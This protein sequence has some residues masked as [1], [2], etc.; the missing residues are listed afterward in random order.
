MLSIP[1]FQ[2]VPGPLDTEGTRI[3]NEML[4]DS[5]A[6]MPG[7]ISSVW[8][9]I[10]EHGPAGVLVSL[11]ITAIPQPIQV[12]LTARAGTAYAWQEMQ[13]AGGGTWGVKPGG[14]TGTTGQNPAYERNANTG[15][16]IPTLAVLWPGFLNTTD[17]P[18]QEYIFD[19]CCTTTP[20]HSGSGSGSGSGGGGT[21][22]VACCPG[23][24][25]QTLYATLTNVSGCACLDGVVVA[26]TWN[27]GSWSGMSGSVCSGHTA[28]VDVLCTEEG[29]W[30]IGV[31]CFL[32]GVE[33]GAG[34]DT[35][36]TFTCDPL[37][38][39][40]AEFSLS[41]CCTGSITVTVTT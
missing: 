34:E 27:G 29:T 31:E 19:L 40:T 35:V 36:M 38:V 20:A 33:D 5:E 23:G 21:V 2:F 24:L 32:D 13:P 3:L 16:P 28:F 4:R 17:P 26:V 10:V 22:T 37:S 6:L 7:G 18:G 15:V 1:N 25:P 30:V 8:P 14:R 9:I 39:T 12:Q 41:G 11:D